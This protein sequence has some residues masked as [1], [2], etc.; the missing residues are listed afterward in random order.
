MKRSHFWCVIII[1]SIIEI[2]LLKVGTGDSN[3]I[4][5]VSAIALLAVTGVLYWALVLR[6]EDAG[7]SGWLV[8][9]IFIMTLAKM[10]IVILSKDWSMVLGKMTPLAVIVIGILPSKSKITQAV[11]RNDDS[12]EN[13]Q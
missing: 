10:G 9:V 11:Q 8:L 2:I 12:S 5:G 13:D 7:L 4:S 3:D 6:L 1:I